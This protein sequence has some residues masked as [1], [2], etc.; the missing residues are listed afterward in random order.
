MI[1][2]SEV[3]VDSFNSFA[4]F[5]GQGDDPFGPSA[6][7]DRSPDPGVSLPMA[8]ECPIFADGFESGDL[9]AWSSSCP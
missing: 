8:T 3:D 2:D 6:T 7:L 1:P 5:L 9:S 4:T